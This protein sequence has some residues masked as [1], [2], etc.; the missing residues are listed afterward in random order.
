M[1]NKQLSIILWV[2]YTNF[3]RV[4]RLFQVFQIDHRTAGRQDKL[5]SPTAAVPKCWNRRPCQAQLV[6]LHSRIALRQANKCVYNRSHSSPH[7]FHF[8]IRSSSYKCDK[9]IYN[10]WYARWDQVSKSVITFLLSFPLVRSFVEPALKGWRG[11]FGKAAR[12]RQR[13]RTLASRA[14]VLFHIFKASRLYIPETACLIKVTGIDCLDTHARLES[15]RRWKFNNWQ[16]GADCTA[17]LNIRARWSDFVRFRSRE[18]T[19]R[20]I[21]SCVWAKRALAQVVEGTLGEEGKVPRVTEL[22]GA[23]SMLRRASMS[24]QLGKFFGCQGYWPKLE[25]RVPLF[26]VCTEL[27]CPAVWSNICSRCLLCKT[28]PAICPCASIN[29][30]H[31]L[32]VTANST[33]TLW[34]ELRPLSAKSD[35]LRSL[36]R[37]TPTIHPPSPMVRPKVYAYVSLHISCCGYIPSRDQGARRNLGFA[38]PACS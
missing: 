15:A 35:L 27:V 17:N 5:R 2:F 21:I 36:R 23:T 32:H 37:R 34:M 18:L 10:G 22:P 19:G 16:D 26:N 33:R 11:R 29:N 3:Q 30:E 9:P 25:V 28:F 20:Q 4:R 38:W 6:S 7:T 1:N 31:S 13:G 24:E 12:W 8:Q 14:C